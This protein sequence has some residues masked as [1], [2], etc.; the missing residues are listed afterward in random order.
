MGAVDLSSQ[1]FLT[2][3][4]ALAYLGDQGSPQDDQDTLRAH[5]NAVA[6]Y[7]VKLTGRDRLICADSD[8]IDEVRDGDGTEILYLRN[9]PVRSLVSLTINPNWS[10]ASAIVVPVPPATFSD[11]C[12]FDAKSG[13]VILKGSTFPAGPATVAVSYTAGYYLQ[14]TPT[15]GD[16][17]D[18]EA[19]EL[20]MIAANILARRWARYRGQKHGVAS[21]T[22]GDQTI[23]FSPDDVTPAEVK[24]LRRYRR[25]LF[26]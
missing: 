22:R 13:A 12:Y 5:L 20:K 10:T 18:V 1:S 3:E 15:A 19:L 7:M 21:E 9:A 26:A 6:A 8:Q 25:S 11:Q 4:E 2:L 17:A 16:P 23:N 14:D 24:E